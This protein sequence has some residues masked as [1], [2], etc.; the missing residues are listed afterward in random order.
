MNIELFYMNI[1][2]FSLKFHHFYKKKNYRGRGGWTRIRH[3]TLINY[4]LTSCTVHAFS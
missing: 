1:E 2:L 3:V 4:I